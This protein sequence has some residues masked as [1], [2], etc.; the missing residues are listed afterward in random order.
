MNLERLAGIVIIVG[1]A[2][3]ILAAVVSPRLYQ[4]STVA[5][6]V[7]II[8]ENRTRWDVSQLLFG[9]GLAIPPVGLILL[10]LHLSRTQKP[11]VIS[12]GAAAFALGA[13]LGVVFVY[14]Q[15]SDPV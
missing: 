13:L 1:V 14:R 2:I 12:A 7:Q 9:L 3:Y 15:T 4:E 5:K 10:S 8:E 6:R 11:M